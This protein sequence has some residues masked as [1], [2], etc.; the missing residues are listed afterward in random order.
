MLIKAILVTLAASALGQNNNPSAAP[1]NCRPNGYANVDSSGMP[2]GNPSTGQ[3]VLY[4]TG[5][6]G[7]Y[8]PSIAAYGYAG[9]AT[10]ACG[11]YVGLST[12]LHLDGT[13]IGLCSTSSTATTPIYKVGPNE[14]LSPS[15][16]LVNPGSNPVYGTVCVDFGKKRCPYPPG[17]SARLTPVF[18]DTTGSYTT[19]VTFNISATGS[20]MLD[21]LSQGPSLRTDIAEALGINDGP[22]VAFTQVLTGS[23]NTLNIAVLV[24]SSESSTIVSTFTTSA[25]T[26]TSL[27]QKDSTINSAL[28]TVTVNTNSVAT[29][30]KYSSALPRASMRMILLNT[31]GALFTL[32]VALFQSLS[33]S[34]F[35][36]PPQ[37]R[38]PSST[39]SQ[40][41]LPKFYPSVQLL[42]PS[43]GPL[44]QAVAA[45]S[46]AAT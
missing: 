20:K 9:D 17:A 21:S 33:S 42:L 28:G 25:N 10:C 45:F 12:F 3:L 13:G 19:E 35:P 46:L 37:S 31:P 16:A 15:C 24:N 38:Q 36:A 29:I 43:L 26:M 27:I 44:V 4:F 6:L 30:G 23:S 41:P 5:I 34:G 22:R 18:P 11:I 7:N 14:Y 32:Q 2:V 1:A 39:A 40:T 8:A